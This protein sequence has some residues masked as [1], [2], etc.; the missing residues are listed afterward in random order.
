M[1]RRRL[2]EVVQLILLLP[3]VAARADSSGDL[4]CAAADGSCSSRGDQEG[5]RQRRS[6]R[7]QRAHLEDAQ[8]GRR[9]GAFG[10]DPRQSILQQE[11]AELETLAGLYQKRI[12]LLEDLRHGLDDGLGAHLPRP[13]VQALLQGAPPVGEQ[14]VAGV[15]PGPS[16]HEGEEEEDFDDE[17]SVEQSV[18]GSTASAS[19]IGD[20]LVTKAVVPQ[21][22]AVTHIGFMPLRNHR[23]AAPTPIAQ[24]AMPTVLLVAVQA[25]GDICLF[26]M[27]GEL[28]FSFPSGH[29]EA[30]A[31]LAVSPMQ[32]EYVAATVDVGGVMRI[33]RISVRPRRNPHEQRRRVTNPE[34]EKV[35]SHL[36]SPANITVSL[37]AAA[38]VPLIP[39]GNSSTDEKPQITAFLMMSNQGVKYFVAGDSVGWVSV[40]TRNG[41]LHGRVRVSNGEPVAAITSHLGNVIYVSNGKW[42]FLDVD[43]VTARSLV[44]WKYEGD[45]VLQA[46]TDS[47]LTSRILAVDKEGTVWVF[48]MREKRDCKVE[49]RFPRRTVRV[50]MVLASVRGYALAFERARN[51]GG[52]SE[53][54]ALN[55]SHAAK[56]WDDPVRDVSPVAW[57]RSGPPMR[58]WAVL[59]RYQEGDLLAFLSEDGMEIE[60]SELMMQAY[61]PPPGDTLGNFKLPVFAVAMVLVMGY[62]FVKQKGPFDPGM[63]E[64]EE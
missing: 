26:T 46:I 31:Q 47:A 14:V 49:H 30:I 50:P 25:D 41:T 4:S 10:Q 9:H 34:E 28:A 8:L 42:G 37:S 17:E 44:C 45:V 23:S 7:E 60:I 3:L 22:Q 40:I 2:A 58:A 55:M 21:E 62:Q 19:A 61:A 5:L 12:G 54:T 43:K 51:F 16:V 20:F 64:M 6:T 18:A 52:R 1:R 56:G 13:N 48:N 38:R 32:D 24:V 59:K 27:S 15:P 63:S 57:R 33:H 53:M 36:G 29:K 11:L 35:S 39:D